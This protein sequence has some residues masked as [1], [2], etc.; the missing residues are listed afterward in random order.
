M[1]TAQIALVPAEIA[2]L[3][4]ALAAIAE[5]AADPDELPAPNAVQT[6]APPAVLVAVDAVTAAERP[7]P[8]ALHVVTPPAAP[9]AL[10]ALAPLA[11]IEATPFD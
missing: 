11:A 6:M 3:L 10:A 1:L 5:Q 2:T 9:S 4:A 8:M 7:A